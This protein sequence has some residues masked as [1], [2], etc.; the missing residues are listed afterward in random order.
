MRNK[1]SINV[2]E[3]VRVFRMLGEI[4]NLTHQ[5]MNFETTDLVNQFTEKN[6]PEIKLLYYQVVWAWLPKDI[7]DSIENE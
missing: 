3:A 2:D 1:I 7:Q 6:Y 5:P 4:H